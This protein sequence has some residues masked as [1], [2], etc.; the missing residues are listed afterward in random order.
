MRLL[1]SGGR[2]GKL[3]GPRKR[4]S[5]SEIG[6]RRCRWLLLRW[7]GTPRCPV[8]VTETNTPQL[9]GFISFRP[10]PAIGV[11]TWHTGTARLGVPFPCALGRI[12][13]ATAINSA[14]PE[15]AA[16]RRTP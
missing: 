6:S 2:C 8:K 15:V 11:M 16:K 13:A 10:R 9:A 7:D 4:G 12:N 5:G 1:A 3:R 14:L